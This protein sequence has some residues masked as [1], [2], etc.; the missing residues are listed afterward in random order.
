VTGTLV[1]RQDLAKNVIVRHGR[2]LYE[3]FLNG[4]WR[5]LK[6]TVLSR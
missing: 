4:Y 1:I 6:K 2:A 3:G 5:L